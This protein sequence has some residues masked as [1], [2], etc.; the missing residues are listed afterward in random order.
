MTRRNGSSTLPV[1]SVTS[2]SA[3]S[4]K[5]SLVE[6]WECPDDYW[7]KLFDGKFEWKKVIR[8]MGCGYECKDLP[9]S[10]T[11]YLNTTFS[12]LDFSGL[13]ATN[14]TYSPDITTTGSYMGISRS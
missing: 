6:E 5:I 4:R 11:L 8:H 9:L 7:Q 1:R 10:H 2:A 3:G 14:Y 12:L 13:S